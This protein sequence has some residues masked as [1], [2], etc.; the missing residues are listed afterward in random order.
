MILKVMSESLSYFERFLSPSERGKAT[1]DLARLG[2]DAIP[3]LF[4]LFSGEAKNKFGVAYR[5]V[6][7]LGCGYVTAK[8]LGELAKPL[9]PYIRAGIDDGDA[10]AI[11]ASGN[12]GE[13]EEE[14]AL[15]LA[16]H[17]V[18]DPFGSVAAY[19]LV[20]CG[21]NINPRVLSILRSNRQSIASLERAEAFYEPKT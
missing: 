11:E 3:I 13:L 17:L 2:S 6:G 18:S 14:T 21:Q 15:A 8:L 10:Y 1:N 4:S 16:K 19:S 5:S 12:L 20:R 7:A 9:E